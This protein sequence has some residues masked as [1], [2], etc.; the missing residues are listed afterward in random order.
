MYCKKSHVFAHISTEKPFQQN[1]M[2]KTVLLILLPRC[3]LALYNGFLI[4]LKKHQNVF[5]KNQE[6]VLEELMRYIFQ[7]EIKLDES[8][9]KSV[10]NTLINIS[11]SHKTFNNNYNLSLKSREFSK[12]ILLSILDHFKQIPR[13]FD[14]IALNHSKFDLKDFH[15]SLQ[16]DYY[17]SLI[18]N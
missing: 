5:L 16:H 3:S 1:C 6:T 12:L 15:E 11:D 10:K 13:I 14:V 17:I 8:M 9:T 7:L 4:L 18:L 2:R